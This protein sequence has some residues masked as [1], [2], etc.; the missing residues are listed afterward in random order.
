MVPC[1]GPR[2]AEQGRGLHGDAARPSAV[3]EQQR[4]GAAR[5]VF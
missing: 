1:R 4:P 3:L 2:Q 5:P